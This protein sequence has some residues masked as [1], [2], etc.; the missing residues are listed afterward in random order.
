MKREKHI[1]GYN[2]LKGILGFLFKVCY[3]PKYYNKEFIPNNGP[4]IIAGNHMHLFD[5]NL[6]ILS[7]KRMVHYMAKIEYFQDNK[8]AWFF[9]MAGC[10]PVNREIKDEEAK[11]SAMEVLNN[12]YALGVFPEGTRNK[13]D[14]FLLPFKFGVVSMAQKSG[15]SIIPC[16]ITGEYKVWK[17]NYLNIRFGK[18]FKVPKDMDLKIA[19]DKLFEEISNLKR[20]GLKGIENEK[21]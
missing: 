14:A 3:Q 4:I 17:R 9:K 20:E 13:I 10:I 18:P 16:A 2:F 7:T 15:A 21:H 6:V 5:Q 8:K 12:G 19:N 11:S 1:K